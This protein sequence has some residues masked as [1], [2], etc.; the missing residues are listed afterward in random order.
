MLVLGIWAQ[1]GS[2]GQK[3][4]EN[5]GFNEDKIAELAATVSILLEVK[6]SVEKIYICN[7]ICCLKCQPLEKWLLHVIKVG[8]SNQITLYYV[9]AHPIEAGKLNDDYSCLKAANNLIVT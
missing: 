5:L 6:D 2:A 7:F 3:V 8:R 9:Q 4:L 1:K